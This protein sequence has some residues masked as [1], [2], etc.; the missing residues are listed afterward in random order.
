MVVVLLLGWLLPL[1]F[2]A[3]IML[4]FVTSAISNQINKTVELSADKAVEVCQMNLEEAVRYSRNATY[5]STIENSYD[6]FLVDQREHALYR[7]VTG[8]LNQYYSY[9]E[10]FVS[11]M[12]FFLDNPQ[13]VYYSVY[14]YRVNPYMINTEPIHFYQE[15]IHEAVIERGHELG[16]D[17][18]LIYLHDRLYLIRNL[19][20]I[21]YQPY[22]MLAIELDKERLFQSLNSVWG[23]ANY[24]VFV[25]GVGILEHEID[26]DATNFQKTVLFGKH[27]ITYQIEL[28]S[29]SLIRELS[30]VR[31]LFGLVIIFLLPLF[32]LVIRFFRT[33][34]TKPV[35][36]LVDASRKIQNGE[37]GHQIQNISDSEEF[38]YL[39]D[40][41]NRMSKELKHQFERIYLGELAVRDASI[42][43]LQSQINPHFLN[44]TLEIINWEARLD[45]NEKV[46]KMI[47]ALSTMLRFTMKRDH[48]NYHTLAEEF[49]YIDAYL[50]II[51]QRFG[52]RFHIEKEIDETLLDSEIPRLIVQPILENAVE[53]GMK[54]CKIANVIVK[55]SKDDD[56]IFIQIINDRKLTEKEKNNI[57]QLLQV[58][59]DP[60]KLSGSL[61]IK[62]VNKRLKII[63]GE[64][65]GLEIICDEEE[66]TVSTITIPLKTENNHLE[67]DH[68]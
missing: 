9:N 50:Y 7:Q 8:F 43:A 18:E 52:S 16:T 33:K 13:N 66:R 61:G 40:A 37:Y 27:V 24:E 31:S 32:Y 65:S 23:S 10:L 29:R 25:D 39:I 64:S 6:Q 28:D 14:V 57:D 45:G 49:T 19:V 68:A 63:Y 20:D 41:Y 21:Y 26:M 35:A 3:N 2:I 1:T 11:T 56:R 30:Y 67:E 58:K 47:E 44:N 46:T 55:V 34:V 38:T 59:P 42:E 5:I 54:D 62:N 17:I 15:Y 22:A 60:K 4:Y 53:H 12:L 51:G 48:K 36:N